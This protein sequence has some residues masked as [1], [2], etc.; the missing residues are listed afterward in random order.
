MLLDP[1]QLTLDGEGFQIDPKY[2]GAFQLH[3]KKTIKLICMVVFCDILIFIDFL[4]GNV[5][6]FEVAS[7]DCL[8]DSYERFFY[9][10]ETCDVKFNEDAFHYHPYFCFFTD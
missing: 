3:Q 6:V 4:D 5:R 9:F 2:D 10:Y 7:P 8:E 1:E